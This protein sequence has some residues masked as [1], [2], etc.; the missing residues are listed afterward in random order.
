MIKGDERLSI[1]LTIRPQSRGSLSVNY[2]FCILGSTDP[3]LHVE[4][5]CIGEGPVI[6]V[7]PG[8]LDW[9]V[10]PVLTPIPKRLILSN[11]SEIEATFETIFVSI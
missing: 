10:C 1:P 3:P 6:S 2:Q 4:I 7:T 9:G 11:E 8:Q 5:H